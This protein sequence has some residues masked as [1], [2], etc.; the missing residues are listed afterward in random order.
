M[1]PQLGADGGPT[2]A[3]PE[4]QPRGLR[5]P[6]AA[7]TAGARTTARNFC[8]VSGSVYVAS[9]PTAAP[10]SVRIRSAKVLGSSFAPASDASCRNVRMVPCLAP[11]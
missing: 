2:N 9:I 1:Q 7:T 5:L 8:C 4:Q 10:F 3:R 11:V 6:A